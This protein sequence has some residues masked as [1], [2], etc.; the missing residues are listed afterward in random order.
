[1]ESIKVGMAEYRVALAPERLQSIGLGS[2]LGIVL[3]DTKHRIGG[4]AHI[5]LP[6]RSEGKV[7]NNPARYAD[8]AVALML[9]E[10]RAL[11]AHESRIVAKVFGGANMFP[12]ITSTQASIGL[13]NYTVTAEELAARKIPVVAVDVG[14]H[15]GRSIL[16][17]LSNGIVHIR[18]ATGQE[19][20]F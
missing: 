9:E 2:C 15:C 6:R 8:S 18:M 13:R 5:M 20:R 14:G 7:K 16:F 3:Y 19:A 1:M 4:L 10:M 12:M 11:G 17:D